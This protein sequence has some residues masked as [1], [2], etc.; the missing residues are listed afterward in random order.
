MTTHSIALTNLRWNDRS[1][2]IRHWKHLCEAI[3]SLNIYRSVDVIL[4]I[5][6]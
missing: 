4:A 2:S 5:F 1:L 3:E 6:Q